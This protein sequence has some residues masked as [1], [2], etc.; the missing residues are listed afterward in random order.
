MGWTLRGLLFVGGWLL[1]AAGGVACSVIGVHRG[2]WRLI[3]PPEVEDAG[4]PRGRRLVSSAPT[5]Q[6]HEV[7][8]LGS[9]AECLEAKR[10]EID[11]TIDRARAEVGD[12]AKYELP[13]RRAVNAR[14]V[15]GK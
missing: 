6:W 7:A 9:E 8:A 4:A 10:A 3:Q 1:L 5:S 15:H 2:G 14:C 13:V 11:R 12:E